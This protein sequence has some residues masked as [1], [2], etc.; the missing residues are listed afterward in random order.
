MC[1]KN[2]KA[3]AGNVTMTIER[4]NELQAELA[5]AKRRTDFYI[6]IG[7]RNGNRYQSLRATVDTV[8]A[9]CPA[10]DA[11]RAFIGDR[12]RSALAIAATVDA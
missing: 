2:C 4:F 10:T 6:R 1:G 5:A 9:M 7:A 11:A 3:S 8:A 12:L